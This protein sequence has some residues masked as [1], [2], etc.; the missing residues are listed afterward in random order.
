VIEASVLSILAQADLVKQARDGQAPIILL[1]EIA[2]HLD[3]RRRGA[4]R[5]FDG[6]AAA[7]GVN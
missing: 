6:T 3:E 1:D 4:E 5:Y 2:A 7:W